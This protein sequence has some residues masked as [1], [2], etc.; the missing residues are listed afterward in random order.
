MEEL[1][2]KNCHKKLGA[3]LKGKVEIV[4][5]RCGVFNTFDADQTLLNLEKYG[6][7]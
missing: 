6:K 3:N 7:L 5:P 1:R 2:C 4:C